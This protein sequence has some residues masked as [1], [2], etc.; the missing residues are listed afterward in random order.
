MIVMILMIGCNHKNNSDNYEK[1]WPMFGLRKN[2]ELNLAVGVGSMYNWTID[3]RP[4][5]IRCIGNHIHEINFWGVV[6]DEIFFCADNGVVTHIILL[7][8]ENITKD[9]YFH[10]KKNMIKE[11]GDADI[12]EGPT[13]CVCSNDTT[14]GEL[15]FNTN[16]YVLTLY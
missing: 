15:I 13:G 6:W 10:L 1:V 5:Y 9:T 11:Y 12:T 2:W 14:H 4:E 3:A 8:H 16:G 7:K